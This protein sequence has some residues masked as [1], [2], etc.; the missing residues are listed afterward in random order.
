MKRSRSGSSGELARRTEEYSAERISS[1]QRQGPMWPTLARFD[2]SRMMRR[3]CRGLMAATDFQ[4]NMDNRLPYGRGSVTN[5]RGK[6]SLAHGYHYVDCAADQAQQW[7]RLHHRFD[8]LHGLRHPIRTEHRHEAGGFFVD[9]CTAGLFHPTLHP[10]TT[11]GFLV[12][13]DMV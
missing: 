1:T 10:T 4:A 11:V 8:E 3:M 7:N 9:D 12:V 5:D 13:L 6:W 2:W